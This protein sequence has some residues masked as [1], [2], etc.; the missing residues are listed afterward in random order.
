MRIPDRSA[1]RIRLFDSAYR[2]ESTRWH[3]DKKSF[4]PMKTGLS[5]NWRWRKWNSHFSAAFKPKRGGRSC[6]DYTDKEVKD[7]SGAIKE[8]NIKPHRDAE[9]DE[10]LTQDG[11]VHTQT[12]KRFHWTILMKWQCQSSDIS[13]SCKKKKKTHTCD[14]ALNFT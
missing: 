7:L 1:S 5:D 14:S 10:A 3:Y 11:R 4:W 8:S 12:Q 6:S 2:S 13:H 9:Q